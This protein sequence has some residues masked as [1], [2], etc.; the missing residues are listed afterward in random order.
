[1]GILKKQKIKPQEE[2]EMLIPYSIKD[3]IENG[4]SVS[5]EIVHVQDWYDDLFYVNGKCIIISN[6]IRINLQNT[7]SLGL[8]VVL[9]VKNKDGEVIVGK[10]HDTSRILDAYSILLFKQ[11]R[12]FLL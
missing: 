4:E 10:T 6:F 12:Q 5:V 2:I 3:K 1:M 11:L 9:C 7:L 8:Y